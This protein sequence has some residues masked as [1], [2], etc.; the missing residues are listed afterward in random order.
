MHIYNHI[1]TY[2]YNPVSAIYIHDHY[3]YKNIHTKLYVCVCVY[4]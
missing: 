3:I 4:M 1:H 2:I